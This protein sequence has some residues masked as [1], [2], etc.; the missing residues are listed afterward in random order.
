M[1]MKIESYFK[2]IVYFKILFKY[3]VDYEIIIRGANGVLRR[4]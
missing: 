2:M 4:V 1:T 3:C